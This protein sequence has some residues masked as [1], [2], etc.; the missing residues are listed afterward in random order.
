MKKNLLSIFILLCICSFCR[1]A[2]NETMM[3]P[4]DS[5]LMLLN[6]V[7]QDTTRIRLLE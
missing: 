2:V 5:L 1:A 7:Q 6:R 4:K 3:E